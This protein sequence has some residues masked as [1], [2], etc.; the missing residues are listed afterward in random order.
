MVLHAIRAESPIKEIDNAAVLE[1]ASLNLKQVVRE[2]E[3]PETRVA[4]LAERGR[5]LRMRRHCRKLLRKLLLVLVIDFDVTRIGQ[6]FH[7]SRADFSER[8]VTAGDGQRCGIQN[9]VGE[10]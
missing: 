10:P 5:N 6:H 1:L 4:Q 8:D 2:S 9:Q 7:D 3:E